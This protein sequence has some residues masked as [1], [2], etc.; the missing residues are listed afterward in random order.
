MG[1]SIFKDSTYVL[2]FPWIEVL[3][4]AL[5]NNCPGC[6][7]QVFSPAGDIISRG[8]FPAITRPKPRHERPTATTGG[9]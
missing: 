5:N 3:T 8:S 7:S 2:N 6:V 9:S 4:L 1:I